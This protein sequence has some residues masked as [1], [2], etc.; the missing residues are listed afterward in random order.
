[1]RRTKEQ[2]IADMEAEAVKL[3]RKLRMETVAGVKEAVV[4]SRALVRWYD[5][6]GV[7]FPD[8]NGTVPSAAA[9]LDAC[10]NE[11]EVTL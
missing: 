4:L 3:K 10:A 7:N 8:E 11:P 9:H 2:R 1:M 6:F 5:E